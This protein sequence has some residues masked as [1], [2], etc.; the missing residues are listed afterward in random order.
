MKM[1]NKGYIIDALKK[2]IESLKET[3]WDDNRMIA[4]YDND[5]KKLQ[6][7]VKELEEENDKL[8]AENDKFKE[9]KFFEKIPVGKWFESKKP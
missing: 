5:I 9:E 8:K 4:H 2:Q 7:R 3:I 1:N 6:K